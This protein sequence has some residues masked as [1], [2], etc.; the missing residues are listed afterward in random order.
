MKL[1]DTHAHLYDEAFD[2]DLPQVILRAKEAGVE[3]ILLPAIDA[4]TTPKMWEIVAQYPDYCFGMQ[5]IHPTSI[6]ADYQQE[7][8]SFE[9]ALKQHQPIA[10]GEIGIDLY[11]DKTFI[12][13]QQTVFEYQV[14]RA[15]ELDLPLSLHCRDG[16]APLLNSLKKFDRNKIR[17]VYHCFSGSPDNAREV[18]A[19]GD[20]YFG[21]GGVA[22]FKNARFT[23]RLNEIPLSRILIETDAPYLTPSPF[24]GKRNEPAYVRYIAATLSEVYGVDEVLLAEQTS[25][26]AKKLFSL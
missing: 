1:I 15:I 24:R 11:W 13:Q 4:E 9:E 3:Q 12:A 21:I 5:G 22:T 20:F 6:K 19:L 10:I 7:L 26:N 23:D 18:S 16:F 25:L 14:Q 2:A 17:G 8:D